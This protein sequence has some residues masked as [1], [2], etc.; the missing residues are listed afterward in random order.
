MIN[1]DMIGRLNDTTH[2]LT[3]AGYGTSSLWAPVCNAIRDKKYISPRNI[4]T[5]S[6]IAGAT[7]GDQLAFYRA[8]IPVLTFTTGIPADDHQ[9]G[10]DAGKINYPGELQVL[11]FIYSV[12]EG[13]NSRGRATFTATADNQPLTATP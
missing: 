7:T 12:I 3:I 5:A 9:P 1:M 11:K 13:A 4:N 6:I 2:A 10:D 8:S